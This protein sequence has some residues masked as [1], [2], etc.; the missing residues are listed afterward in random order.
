MHK[1]CGI[2]AVLLAVVFAAVT[3]GPMPAAAASKSDEQKRIE[4]EHEMKRQA[5]RQKEIDKT[6]RELERNRQWRQQ[7]GNDANINQN[8]LNDRTRDLD[9]RKQQL[10]RQQR[11][12]KEKYLGAQKNSNSGRQG[13][14]QTVAQENQRDAGRYGTFGRQ[15]QGQY[16]GQQKRDW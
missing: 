7:H 5:D 11:E 1:I 15:G 2:I 16:Q 4:R 14:G 9:A 8:K 6:N 10:E 3:L 13:G 12:G